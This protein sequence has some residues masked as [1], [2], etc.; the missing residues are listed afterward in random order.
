VR[1]LA[2]SSI[3]VDIFIEYDVSNILCDAEYFEWR[4]TPQQV[5]DIRIGVRHPE[6]LEYTRTRRLRVID[7]KLRIG[8]IR[9]DRM[10]HVRRDTRRTIAQQ[11]LR[12]LLQG[13]TTLHEIID[14]DTA[15]TDTRSMTSVS[16][17]TPNLRAAGHFIA[18]AAVHRR[19]TSVCRRCRPLSISPRACHHHEPERT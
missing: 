13:A 17:R 18:L 10:R 11:L 14:D 5:G 8:V 16:R 7:D 3:I 1:F 15:H 9:K 6:V 4:L 19:V 2:S 12:T